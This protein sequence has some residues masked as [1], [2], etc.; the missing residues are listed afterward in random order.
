MTFG[1]ERMGFELFSGI[2][3]AVLRDLEAGEAETSFLRLVFGSDSGNCKL[4]SSSAS[5]FALIFAGPLEAFWLRT[6]CSSSR[7]E[8]ATPF[9]GES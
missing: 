6:N 8:P 2:L 4:V 7:L 5:F 9:C 1:S 3:E